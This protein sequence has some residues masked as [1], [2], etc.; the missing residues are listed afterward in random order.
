MLTAE[1][2]RLLTRI[3]PGTVM[4]ELQRRYWHPILAVEDMQDRH[5]K[6]VRLLGEDLILFKDGQGRFGL[7]AESR[8]YR[9]EELG[10]VLFAYLGP[11]PAPL[12][13][14]Y[15]G[16]V[17]GGPAIRMF[18]RTLVPCNWLQ[19]MENSVDPIHAE[20]LHGHLAEFVAEQRGMKV[21]HSRK[22][23]KIAFDEFELGIYK[24]RLL[25]GASEESDDWKVGHPV[26]FPNTLA[27][28]SGGGT[29]WTMHAYQIRVPLDDENTL[30]VWYDVFV[31]PKDLEVPAHLLERVPA[32]DVPYLDANG[33]FLLDVVDVQDI[34]A[35]VTQ[36]RIAERDR[37]SLG[38]T[39]RGITLYR[40]IL[41]RE[42]K[43]I[44]AGEDPIGVFRDPARNEVI[45]FPI[46]RDK[47]HFS[48]GFASY[49]E[50]VHNRFYPFAED[51]KRVFGTR[52]EPKVATPA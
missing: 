32:Y 49:M 3:G 40:R 26:I 47:I 12:V 16:F 15:D 1:E 2:N 24:R 18:G 23:L 21:A 19:I 52:Y 6:P 22:H 48:D 7:N 46:E 43:K 29:L 50:R 5:S 42:L 44:A 41:H 51:L 13:P 8:A 36:G 35:W 25:A 20:W 11:E 27:V 30:H 39:D 28:G 37:E 17:T 34:M 4:G 38:A 31:P 10:G 45:T 33:E 9:I 14:R